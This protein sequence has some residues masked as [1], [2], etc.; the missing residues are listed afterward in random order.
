VPHTGRG[1]PSIAG[2]A[3]ARG[4]FYALYIIERFTT[5]AEA[6]LQIWYCPSTWNPY[7]DVLMNLPET[8]LATASP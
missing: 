5:V 8:R 7:I 3:A 1:R 6:E 4:V 2:R